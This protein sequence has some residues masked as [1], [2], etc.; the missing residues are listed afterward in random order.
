VRGEAASLVAAIERAEA[1]PEDQLPVLGKPKGRPRPDA[2]VERRMAR[3]KAWRAEEAERSGLD[4]SIVL[5][6][7]LI[8]KVAGRGPRTLDELAGIDGIRRWR[9]QAYGT[10][11]L[12]G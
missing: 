2:A 8:D 9:V 12:A 4:V 6:Q 5:P 3:L 1:L 10:A 11:L 7:R